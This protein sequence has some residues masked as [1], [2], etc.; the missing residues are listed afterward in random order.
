MAKAKS[1]S[2]KGSGWHLQ[3]QRHRQARLTGRAGGTYAKRQIMP[4]PRP[5]YDPIRN[6]EKSGYVEIKNKPKDLQYQGAGE[7]GTFYYSKSKDKTYIKAWNSKKYFEYSPTRATITKDR[8]GHYNVYIVDRPLKNGKIQGNIVK[9]FKTKKEA[10]EWL[11]DGVPDKFDCEPLNP[12]KQDYAEK[13]HK[14]FPINKEYEIEA[15]W[16]RTRN[17]FR[18]V[19]IL[20]KNGVEVDRARANY[21]NRTWESYEYETV[22]KDLL[23]DN[24][25]LTQAQKDKFFGKTEKKD[26]EEIE[27]KFGTI[28]AIAKMG[29]VLATTKKERIDWKKRMLKAGIPELDIPSDWDK[30]SD[31]EKEKRLDKVIDFMS[32]KKHKDTDGDGVP[33]EKDCKPLD[34]KQ[35]GWLHDQSVK[36]L[37]RREQRLEEKR[38]KEMKKLEALKEKLHETNAKTQAKLDDKQ[39]KLAEKQAIID[40]INKEKRQAEELREANK[41]V[42]RELRKGK[43]TTKISQTSVAVLK[44]TG[45]AIREGA[46]DVK[47]W[48]EKPSTKKAI[49]KGLRTTRA[50]LKKIF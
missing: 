19:A 12:K 9:S 43:I 11:G 40:E 39:E 2:G 32:S 31:D 17:G 30:L 7:L 3:S 34:P 48:Y 14:T 16:Q 13:G 23:A 41:E 29:E 50:E 37:K 27:R 25:N 6:L 22:M 33:D 49:K 24:P 15:Y 8:T 42:K 47:D 1:R 28:S 35:Q 5:S 10:Q 26:T 38:I 46:K 4:D 36:L 45:K 18:H 21:L 20:K 44:A